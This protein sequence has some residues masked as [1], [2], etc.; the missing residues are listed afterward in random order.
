[1]EWPLT[2]RKDIEDFRVTVDMIFR[3]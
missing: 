3:Y 2:G 1:V